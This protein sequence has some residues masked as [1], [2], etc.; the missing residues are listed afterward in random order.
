MS[1]SDTRKDG[2]TL[3][4]PEES[5]QYFRANGVPKVVCQEKHMGSRAVAVVCR[6]MDVAA[7]RF[8]IRGHGIGPST[9]GREGPS[10]TIPRSSPVFSIASAPR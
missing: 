3:E 2:P 8:G 7:K 4:H 10:S 5:F 6:D 1:P 9:R